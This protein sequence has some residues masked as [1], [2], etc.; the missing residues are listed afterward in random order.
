MSV[1]AV[2]VAEATD[3]L[4]ALKAYF[5]Q[6]GSGFAPTPDW[7]EK[8]RQALWSRGPAVQPY[9]LHEGEAR[10][11]LAVAGLEGHPYGFGTIGFV[12]EFGLFE[13]YRGQGLAAASARDLLGELRRQGARSIQLEVLPGNA[14]AAALWRSLGFSLRAERWVSA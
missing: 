4:V 3:F 1:R 12:R 13:A 9:W 8:M 14:A 5:G 7:E 6:L 2:E 10:I 11:G